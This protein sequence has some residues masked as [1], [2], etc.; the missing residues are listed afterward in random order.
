MKYKIVSN[1]AK[2]SALQI[3]GCD[4][5]MDG[6]IFSMMITYLIRSRLFLLELHIMLTHKTQVT[7]DTGTKASLKIQ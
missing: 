5:R 7:T 2:L 1:T 6:F 4:I 3:N